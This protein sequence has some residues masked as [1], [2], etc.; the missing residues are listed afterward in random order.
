MKNQKTAYDR[1]LEI[2]PGAVVWS[3]LILPVVLS[4]SHAYLVA[5]FIIVFDLWWLFRAFSIS[6][7]L[8]RSHFWVKETLSQNWYE[9]CKKTQNL[10]NYLKELEHQKIELEQQYKCLKKSGLGFFRGIERTIHRSHHRKYNALVGEIENLKGVLAEKSQINFDDLYHL[11]IMATYQEEIE[12]LRP[13]VKAVVDA[14][15]PKDKIIF[16]LAAEQRDYPRAKANAEILE[17]EFGSRFYKFIVTYHPDNI[18]GEVKG[19]GANISYAG[20]Q[21]KKIID[22]EKISYQNI[23]TTSLDAD[24][25]IHPMYFYRLSYT[26]VTA[27]ERTKRSY[28]PLPF[29]DNN[30]WDTQG[31]SRLFALS[32]AFWFMVES[33]RPHRLRNFAAHAQ[34]FQTLIDTDFWA[35]DSIVEDGHQFWRTLVRYDGNHRAVPLFV[36]VYQDA[37][38]GRHVGETLKNLYLQHR[39]WAWGVTDIPFFIKNCLFNAKIKLSLRLYYFWRVFEGSVTWATT[40]LLLTFVGWMP[41]LLSS[42]YKYTV[43]SQQL[44]LISTMLLGLALVGVLATLYIAW[45]VLPPRPKGHNSVVLLFQWLWTPLTFFTSCLPALDAVTRLMLGRYLEFWT[46]PKRVKKKEASVEAAEV[47]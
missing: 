46:T 41:L 23:I 40:P 8:F 42:T 36:P 21:V 33:S 14:Y 44:W 2:F 3:L 35:V 29:F 9:K 43:I 6:K 26:Y 34:S 17:K 18:P 5:Y 10:G 4:F 39:R 20:R 38:L 19:K 7:N 37:V 13:A 15:Y 22:R 45:L 25:R 12:T 1:A 47:G 11:V 32:C 27:P 28:Q 24:H 31:V 30:I 16:V